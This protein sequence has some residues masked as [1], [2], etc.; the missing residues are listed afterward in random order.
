MRDVAGSG[1]IPDGERIAGFF[2]MD[3]AAEVR[4]LQRFRLYSQVGNATNAAFVSSQRPFG[5]RP[6]AP[7]TVM[8]GVKAHILP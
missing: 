8:V 6:G 4:V 2:T 1:S 3:I 7:L 5:I